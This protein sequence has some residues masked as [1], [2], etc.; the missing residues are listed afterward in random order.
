MSGKKMVSWFVVAAFIFSSSGPTYLWAF[1]GARQK[2]YLRAPAENGSSVNEALAMKG[3]EEITSTKV[4]DSPRETIEQVKNRIVAKLGKD[5]ID[6][7]HHGLRHSEDLIERA[8]VLAKK[9]EVENKVDWRVLTAEIILHDINALEK[10]HGEE[11]AFF[12][13]LF[14]SQ[15][16]QF[17]REDINKVEL[18]IKLH[19]ERDGEGRR[20][21]KRAGLEAQLLYDVDRSFNKVFGMLSG[22]KV[23]AA[24]QGALFLNPDT[25]SPYYKHPVAIE[26]RKKIPLTEQELEEIAIQVGQPKKKI[27]QFLSVGIFSTFVPYLMQLTDGQRLAEK[28]STVDLS[29][30]LS[31]IIEKLTAVDSSTFVVAPLIVGLVIGAGGF[32]EEN[33]VDPSDEEAFRK[34]LRSMEDALSRSRK[35][36]LGEEENIIKNPIGPVNPKHFSIAQIVNSL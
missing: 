33:L 11:N 25:N 14:L 3:K 30:I 7:V 1:P 23:G 15:L 10:S 34:L 9:L 4:A 27:T 6:N 13:K 5:Y 21:R 18:G 31:S 17:E 24:Y 19:G 8:L 26:L 2:Q 29:A 12:A 36:S 28:I 22:K 16:V 35:G 32:S 20:L